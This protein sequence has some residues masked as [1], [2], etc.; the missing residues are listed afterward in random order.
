MCLSG[1]TC[2]TCKKDGEACGGSSLNCCNNYC[3]F[4]TNLCGPS[5]IGGTC[6]VPTDCASTALCKKDSGV[7]VGICTL[8]DGAACTADAQCYSGICDASSG[9]CGCGADGTGCTRDTDCCG[10][11][12]FPTPK[13][14][15][16]K[17]CGCL[18]LGVHCGVMADCC[19]GVIC[20]S[21]TSTCGCSKATAACNSNADC[22]SGT[23]CGAAKTCCK[24]S[25]ALCGAGG[26]CCSGNCKGSGACQ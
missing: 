10:S 25:G 19:G 26:E 14:N 24:A 1:G 7:A 11:G 6:E 5:P 18:A 4:S 16:V 15:T 13:C 12:A 3:N 17:T 22:C 20:N 8:N 21:A 2:G 9:K 23:T